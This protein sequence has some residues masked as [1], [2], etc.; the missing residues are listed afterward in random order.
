[1]YEIMLTIDGQGVHVP[2]GTT[3]LEAARH[4]GIYIPTLCYHPDLPPAGD[5]PP[6]GVV[7]QGECRIENA[8]PKETAPRCGLCVVEVEGRDDLVESCAAQAVDGMVVTTDSQRIRT[9]R[10]KNLIP[11][12]A[13]HPHACL[14]CAQQEG[15]SRT[16][17]S[18]NVPENERCCSRFGDCELQ[19]VAGYVGI[20]EDTPRWVPTDLP[21]LEDMPLFLRDDNLCIGCTRCVRACRD[22]RGVEAIGF[23]RDKQGHVRIG[24]LAPTMEES[25]CRFCTACVEVCPTGAL[26]D[27][28]VRPEKRAK[29]LVPCKEAC[30]AR[31]DVPEYVR[32]TAQGEPDEA[33]AVIRE[34]V[35]FPGVL[36]R[37]CVHPCEEVCRR[38]RINEPIAVCA[39]KR[40]AADAGGGFR[41]RDLRIGRNTGKRVAVVGAGP[42]GLTAAFYLCKAGHEVTL[43]EA[44]E[45]AGGMMRYGIP[46]YRL[47][48][49]VL[50]REIQD[51]LDLGVHFRPGRS[52]GRDI[53]LEGL[54][55]NGFH[56]VFLAVGAQAGRTLDIRGVDLPGVILGVEFLKQAAEGG[57]PELKARI[58]VVGGGRVSV[59]AA[60]T[61]LRYGAREVSVACLE[62]REEM[63]APA[64]DVEAL[65]SEGVKLLPCRGLLRIIG[66]QGGVSGAELVSC[67]RVFDDRGVCSPVFDEETRKT[68][69]A[70]Q[71]ILAVGQS[72]DLSFLK[73]DT[74]I[75]VDGGLI[76]VNP[77][78]QETGMRNV[79]AGGD[80]AAVPGSVIHAVAAGRRAAA[81]MDEALGG[82]GDMDERLMPRKTP[83]PRLGREQG[84]AQ[85][86]REPVPERDPE[87]RRTGFEEVVTGYDEAAA[88]REASRCLQCDLRLH[89][90]GNPPPPRA[91][92]GLAE[93]AIGG[94][95]EAEGVFQ[96]MDE[97]HRVLSIRGTANLRQA[98]FQEL[99]GNDKA[100]LFAFEEDKMYS[101][102]ESELL[103]KHLQVHGEMPGDGEGLD[104]LF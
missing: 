37:V 72:A 52:L 85:R 13:R 16:Q 28:H 94:V 91:W 70:D 31:I 6:A 50:D 96:L 10:R 8:R 54:R 45:D 79:F 18:S 21:L 75:R 66:G 88:V 84:F 97:D 19:D 36:G 46:A 33:D 20:S 12:L 61:A 29:D 82:T 71:I 104:D 65:L 7:Y 11:I 27:K 15:C 64:G 86:P 40:Y 68:V 25:G 9:E 89:I 57:A 17:C 3:I 1:M 41:R 44:K 34:K 103:Q 100:A 60:L 76:V 56:A 98:L 87:A 24:T 67:T 81:A 43:Y 78:T 48:R 38:G 74:P 39:L 92:L 23:V 53:D 42:A 58:L 14:T 99:E 77:H 47:P 90:E 80:V 5:T 73:E 51:V 101:K 63:P 22:L 62:S 30:P 95:P 102:R 83:D 2:G 32:L 26:R 35:P 59:D 55:N 4:A 69:S 49:D 93:E